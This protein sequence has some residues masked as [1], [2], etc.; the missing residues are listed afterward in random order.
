MPNA[1]LS[2]HADTPAVAGVF[3]TLSFLRTPAAPDAPARRLVSRTLQ[4]PFS[5]T[6]R[7]FGTRAL[8][9]E[10]TGHADAV[11]VAGLTGQPLSLHTADGDATL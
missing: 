6:T 3:C 2:Q 8:N 1:L 9:N 10:T 7:L 4:Q 11:T 5:R